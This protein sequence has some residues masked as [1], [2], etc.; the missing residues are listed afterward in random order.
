MP[1][2]KDFEQDLCADIDGF[3]LH[4]AVRC[5][6]DDRQTL[7]QVCRCITRPPFPTNAYKPTLPGKSC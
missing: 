1:R 4:A 7:E 5:N 6:A 2:E 3:S